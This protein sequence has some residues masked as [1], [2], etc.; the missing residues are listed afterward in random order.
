EKSANCKHAI[1]AYE[2]AL[3]VSTLEEFPMDYAMTQ[4]NLGNAYSTL[5]EV[6][7]KS[8]NCKHAIR[9]YES[10]LKVFSKE[11]FPEVYPLIIANYKN[12]LS[13]CQQS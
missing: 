11:E 12:V 4:N 5:A 10:A 7:E 6:E 13:Y 3:K 9:A 2:S 1:R 8:A